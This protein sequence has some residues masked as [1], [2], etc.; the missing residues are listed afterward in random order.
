MQSHSPTRSNNHHAATR[1]RLAGSVRFLFSFLLLSPLATVLTGGTCPTVACAAEQTPDAEL[2]APPRTGWRGVFFNPQ[3]AAVGDLPWLLHYGAHREM[4]QRVLAELRANI[5]INLV[6]VQVLIPHSLR[7]P[8]R[9]NLVGEPIEEWA[10]TGF[11]DNIALFVDDCHAAGVAVELDLADNRWLPSTVDPEGHIGKPGNAWWPQPD[12]TPW[13]E[14]AEW[15]AGVIRYV[16]MR[17][18]HPEAIA[19][20]CLMGNYALGGAEPV[21]WHNSNRPEIGQF[22]EQFVKAVWPV[23]RTAGKRPKA[24]PILFP[25][26]AAD[27]YW[28]TKPPADRLSGFMNLKR[29]IVDDLEQPPDYWVMSTYPSCDPAPDGVRYLEKI[30]DIL[31]PANAR[32]ILSTDLKGP[33]H[34]DE[35]RG[36]ILNGEDV[37]GP[38]ILRWHF[39][40]CREYG[41]AGWWIW[42]YQD[43]PTSKMGLRSMD[44]TWKAEL[45]SEILHCQDGEP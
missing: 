5:G 29:W 17:S 2:P 10:N 9:G 34:E 8:A 15:Y 20:W 39:A 16:E 4:V 33:G 43:T 1:S 13:D 37:A 30:V 11:L 41:F 45:V 35:I 12:S 32:R 14:A 24:A 7:V 6:D 19:M 38:E 23:F 44:G 31:G 3:V 42:A 36:T 40:K 25:I 27:D 21:L 22:T 18:A 28:R 26:F